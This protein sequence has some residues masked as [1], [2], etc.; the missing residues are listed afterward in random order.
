MPLYRASW[1]PAASVIVTSVGTISTIFGINRFVSSIRA[2]QRKAAHDR[3]ED[4]ADEEV[5]PGP[6]S[7]RRRRGRR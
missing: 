7:R 5:D 6:E 1:N 4:E 3:T 2:G